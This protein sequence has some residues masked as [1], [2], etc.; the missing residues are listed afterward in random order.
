MIRVELLI[1]AALLAMLAM[2]AR[3][4]GTLLALAACTLRQLGA[5]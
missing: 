5:E 4:E 1:A 2:P 3:A